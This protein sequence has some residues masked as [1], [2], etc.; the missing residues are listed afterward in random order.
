M[1][2]SSLNRKKANKN[3]KALLALIYGNA[4]F[5]AQT[6]SVGTSVQTL[7][8]VSPYPSSGLSPTEVSA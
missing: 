2:T 5:F 1:H 7:T 8:C 6:F 4:L 3:V